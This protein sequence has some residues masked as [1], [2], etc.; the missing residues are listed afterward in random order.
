MAYVKLS[1]TY[2]AHAGPVEAEQVLRKVLQDLGT[3]QE[4][5][6]ASRIDLF[7]D[8]VSSVDMESWGREA[9]VTRAASINAYSV[10]GKFS[11]WSV[12]LGGDMACRLYDKTL[13]ISVSKK[14]YLH[15][16]WRQAGWD[17]ASCVW[18]LEFQFKRTIL[19]QHGLS[20]LNDVLA[21]LNGLWD[22]ATTGWLR[23]TLPNPDDQTRSRWPVHPLWGYLASVDWETP[24]GLLSR[25]FSPARVPGDDKLF[26]LALSLMVS[27]MAREGLRD[28]FAGQE[29]FLAALYQYHADR[30]FRLGLRF[31]DYIAEKV[32][33]KAREFNSMLNPLPADEVRV[34]AERYRRESDGA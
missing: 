29:A 20:R 5:A 26:S 34:R 3:L 32:S 21:H 11:G 23:L 19:T 16:L 6:K 28:F 27:Y 2:L 4:A 25:Q 30:A 18:R 8:F 31:D 13:E 14:A 24:G 9:W 12:G 17:G 22:Y 10:D 15:D 33:I 7:V 1:S